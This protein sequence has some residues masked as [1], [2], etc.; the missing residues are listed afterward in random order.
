MQP[1]ADAVA[2]HFIRATAMRHANACSRSP[3]D[4]VSVG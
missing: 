2:P 3:F 4:I 1:S